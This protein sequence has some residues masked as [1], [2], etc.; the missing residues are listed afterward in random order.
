MLFLLS[1]KESELD[2]SDFEVEQLEFSDFFK[3]EFEIDL[4]QQ[5]LKYKT[6]PSAL[7]LKGKF[8]HNDSTYYA[9]A[10]VFPGYLYFYNALSKTIT[11]EIKLPKA[12][13]CQYP[14]YIN[15]ASF[16]SIIYLDKFN[17]SIVIA[18][19]S[20]IKRKYY[21]NFSKRFHEYMIYNS[22]FSRSELVEGKLVMNPWIAYGKNREKFYVN[23]D[24]LMDLRPMISLY[25]FAKD[26]IIEIP[27]KPYLK[28]NTGKSRIYDAGCFYTFN[29]PKKELILFDMASDTLLI[30]NILTKKVKRDYIKNS[31]IS[32]QPIIVTN[33]GDVGT[34]LK[35]IENLVSSRMYYIPQKDYY[36][37]TLKYNEKKGELVNERLLIQIIDT[38]FN[39]T[40][41]FFAPKEYWAST[42]SLPDGIYLLKA[43]DVNQK[44]SY[45]KFKYY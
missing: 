25:D 8:I 35:E 45:A 44:L 1:C 11:K 31:S 22:S 20:G 36:V 29:A 28:R 32:L 14:Y 10:D 5:K 16:D 24:S 13:N 40:T 2:K 39:V 26:S 43:D 41:E 3:T 33:G 7:W 17:Q 23:Y 19:T 6:I 34:F 18:D 4:T 30:Y 9:L 37:R 42:M 27:V 38:K 21:P 12:D 15:V